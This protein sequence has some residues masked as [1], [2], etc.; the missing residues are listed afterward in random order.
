MD[1]KISPRPSLPK[2]GI[3]PPFGL[4][5]PVDDGA[6][7]GVAVQSQTLAPDGEEGFKETFS[8]G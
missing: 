7:G 4:F 5:N 2:R 3:V 6:K 8:N 1:H